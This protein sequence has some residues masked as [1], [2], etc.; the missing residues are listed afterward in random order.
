MKKRNR[1]AARHDHSVAKSP[2]KRKMAAL[3]RS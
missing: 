2:K 3:Q 1:L